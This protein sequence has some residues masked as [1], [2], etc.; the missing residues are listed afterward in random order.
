MDGHFRVICAIAQLVAVVGIVF[1]W[2][3]VFNA[4]QLPI[5]PAVATTGLG[6]MVII[7]VDAASR[8]KL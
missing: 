8:G 4:T 7:F 3:S 1:T 6:V 5:L 2:L